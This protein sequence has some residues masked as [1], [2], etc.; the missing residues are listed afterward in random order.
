M[1]M[2]KFTVQKYNASKQLVWNQFLDTAKNATFLFR[3]D[4]MDY[5]QDR[6]EEASLMIYKNEVLIALFPANSK[7][8]TLYSHQGLTYGGLVFPET[9]RFKDALGAFK[10]LLDFV[11]NQGIHTI[12]LKVL[13]K[14]YHTYPSDEIDYFLF[15]VGA[16]LYRRDVSSAILNAN[17]LKIQSNRREGV[18]KANK[19]GLK[20]RECDTFDAF[21]SQILIPNLKERHDAK[22]VHSLDEM[23]VLKSR[24]PNNIRQFN[25]YKD[26]GLVAGATVFETKQVAHVQYISANQDKQQLGSLDFLFEQLINT[27]FKHKPY[28]DF[29]ISNENQGLNVNKGLI[30]WKEGFGARSVVHDFY[31]ID[32]T[33]LPNLDLVLI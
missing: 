12:D 7:A 10:A 2:N 26:D 23:Q 3:R 30:G 32:L 4:F 13:P 1:L 15:L 18:R 9:I 16:A 27:V 17:A 31:K 25:V 19:H 21:W 6:F 5:H 8:N 14:I 24:F 22:P 33:Q 29:G 28:F 11:K 20:V